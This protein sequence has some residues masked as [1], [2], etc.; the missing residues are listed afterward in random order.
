[1]RKNVLKR[2]LC[3]LIAALLLF[4]LAGCKSDKR[5]DEKTESDDGPKKNQ[6]VHV[7]ETVQYG[8]M[9]LTF[10]S[11][12]VYDD[13]GP[14]DIELK[15]ECENIGSDECSFIAMGLECF[16][17]G[18]SK[19]SCDY[20]SIDVMPGRVKTITAQYNH[21]RIDQYN[22]IEFDYIDS[23]Y[24]KQWGKITFVVSEG[25]DHNYETVPVP[26]SD[27]IWG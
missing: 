6:V 21:G 16:V 13:H 26:P 11:C 8:D 20:G 19:G 9:K 18:R 10:K 24:S 23:D 4:A 2:L 22:K 1:M 27:M 3:M 17:N 5:K 12:R 15:I 25:S 14:A 7:G